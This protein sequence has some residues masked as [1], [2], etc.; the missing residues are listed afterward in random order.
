ME[1]NKTIEAVVG[2]LVLVLCAMFV[3]L[4]YRSNISS[5]SSI[6]KTYT[7]QAM[8]DRVDGIHQGST[9]MISGIKIG[10]VTDQSLDTKSYNAVLKFSVSSN[11]MLP[12]D[13]SAEIVSNG[14]LG[15]KYIALVPGADSEYLKNGDSIE[16]TQSSINIESLIGKMAFGL[17]SSKD[18]GSSDSDE[19]SDDADDKKDSQA[20]SGQTVNNSLPSGSSKSS[21]GHERHND[22]LFNKVA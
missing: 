4:I 1:G 13:T 18:S 7:L 22:D 2:G 20:S 12:T 9:V 17:D 14:L 15:E 16:F 5:I 3:M 8:F 19:K 6:G 11:I 21:S 10:E